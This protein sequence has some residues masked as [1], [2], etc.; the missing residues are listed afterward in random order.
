MPLRAKGLEMKKYFLLVLVFVSLCISGCHTSRY[1]N[2]ERR[3]EGILFL[4]EDTTEASIQELKLAGNITTLGRISE[5]EDP[6]KIQVWEECRWFYSKTRIVPQGDESNEIKAFMIEVTAKRND[7]LKV[8][9]AE[10][11]TSCIPDEAKPPMDS[12]QEVNKH[13]VCN[14]I[15]EWQMCWKD[16]CPFFNRGEYILLHET[17]LIK[18]KV[19]DW[20]YNK[21]TNVGDFN[22]FVYTDK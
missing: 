21:R 14:D 8:R 20:E 13:F 3:K 2:H 7:I 10:P 1:D 5:F 11:L 12:F 9:L 15:C 4:R 17:E 19:L 22:I 6:R 16:Y 18:F